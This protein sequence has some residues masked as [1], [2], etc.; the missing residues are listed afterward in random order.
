MCVRVIVAINNTFILVIN[1][2]QTTQSWAE[3]EFAN[4]N[5]EDQ[6]RTQRLILIAEQRGSQPHA[7]FSQSCGDAA[8][9]AAAAKAVYRFIISNQL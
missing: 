5:L 4:A 8:A 7:S 2:D 6:R 3:Q 9:A 1:M